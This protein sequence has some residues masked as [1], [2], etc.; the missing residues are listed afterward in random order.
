MAQ[1]VTSWNSA[2]AAEDL[3]AVLQ[4]SAPLFSARPALLAPGRTPQTYKRLFE[5]A[6]FIIRRLRGLGIDRGDRVALIL[7]DGVGDGCSFCVRCIRG[8]LRAAESVL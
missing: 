3:C 8:V 4:H 6:N 7:P 2:P 1:Q 5:V